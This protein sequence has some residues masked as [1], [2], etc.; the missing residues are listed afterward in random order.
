MRRAKEESGAVLVLFALLLTAL[1]VFSSIGVDVA[2]AVQT[3]RRAQSAADAAALAASQGLPG[4][5]TGI[6]SAATYAASN[7]G[8]AG[9]LGPGTACAAGVTCFS[10][11]GWDVR[12]TIPYQGS[13]VRVQV[14]SC[15]AVSSMF[16][17]LVGI[18]SIGV[19]GT[20]AA[21]HTGPFALPGP[22]ILVTRSTGPGALTCGGGCQ[23]SVQRLVV[24]STDSNGLNV[25]GNGSIEAGT[26]GVGGGSSTAAGTGAVTCSA[27]TACPQ[28]GVR[29]DDPYASL[30]N[31]SPAGLS[32][33]PGG[34]YVGPISPGIYTG[35]LRVASDATFLPGVYILQGG[36]TVQSGAVVTGSRVFFFNQAG[37][38][39]ITAG[40]TV[41][42]T[43]LQDG[44]P[45]NDIVVFQARTN[46]S[47]L[48][49]TGGA[50]L[51]LLGVVYNPSGNT[52]LTGGS[53]ASPIRSIVTSTLTVV[54]GANVD[55]RS[56]TDDGTTVGRSEL[57]E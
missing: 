35:R 5:A 17:R 11:G 6:Q 8:V 7:L 22:D 46:T 30:P 56:G 1:M 15:R 50:S 10:R 2:N 14:Q 16:G 32:V 13:D 18:A 12:V 44:S 20:G 33:Y 19:C 39:D 37:D 57:Y 45:Y 26:V 49:L 48:L 36:L 24:N 4:T 28:T 3:R 31:P 40:S 42:L 54:G 21:R 41:S 52:T 47:T 43:P 38:I 27:A 51:S 53:A 25:N 9:G 29:V 23:L 34:A 55:G